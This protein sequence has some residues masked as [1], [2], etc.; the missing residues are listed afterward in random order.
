MYKHSVSSLFFFPATI[1]LINGTDQ[2][3]G[4]VE[5]YHNGQWT[6]AYNLNWGKNEAAV[7]C[8]EM[9]CGDPV[10]FST[11][12]GQ[13]G[14]QTGYRVSCSGTE[15]SVTQCTLREYTKNNKD[16]TEEAA[17][18]CSGKTSTG[19]KRAIRETRQCLP[20]W[21]H[22]WSHSSQFE[23]CTYI[24]KLMLSNIKGHKYI[25]MFLVSI[26]HYSLKWMCSSHPLADLIFWFHIQQMTSLKYSKRQWLFTRIFGNTA[27]T[28]SNCHVEPLQHTL[29]C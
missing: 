1:R 23:M 21:D 12:F 5:F 4:R 15:S 22:S 26:F 24:A 7:V 16:Q 17:V 25:R 20:D 13:A 9:N 18:I 10:E 28:Y 27:E 2:C 19:C 14:Y 6:P 11:L 8:R 3:S 29:V